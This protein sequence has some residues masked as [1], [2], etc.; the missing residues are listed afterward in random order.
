[1]SSYQHWL[2]VFRT[3]LTK[4]VGDQ[5]FSDN[6]RSVVHMDRKHFH[7]ANMKSILRIAIN[8]PGLSLYSLFGLP[9]LSE[10]LHIVLNNYIFVRTSVLTV[11]GHHRDSQGLHPT[12]DK[13]LSILCSKGYIKGVDM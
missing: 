13:S 12:T 11:L 5:T 9:N 2:Y 10:Q 1:M 4:T 8:K 6:F 3:G 7:Y